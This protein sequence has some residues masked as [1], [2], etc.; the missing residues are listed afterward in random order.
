[1][2]IG[3]MA[4]ATGLSASRIRFYEKNGLIPKPERNENGYR[5]YP[6]KLAATLELIR[7]SQALGFSLREIADSLA[8]SWPN[9]PS[10]PEMSEALQDKLVSI[11]QH[12]KLAQRRRREILKLIREFEDCPPEH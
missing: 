10:R 9:A 1:M 7:D 4:R 5:E 12:I 8:K 11:E 2:R 3:E 6:A